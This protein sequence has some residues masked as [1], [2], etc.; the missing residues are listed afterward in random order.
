MYKKVIVSRGEA[1][2]LLVGE[3]KRFK[4]TSRMNVFKILLAD[5]LITKQ[6]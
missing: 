6:Q 4:A 5:I 3:R 2:K 1:S